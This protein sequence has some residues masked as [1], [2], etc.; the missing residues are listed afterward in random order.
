M[1]YTYHKIAYKAGRKYGSIVADR[2]REPI[3]VCASLND[4][5]QQAVAILSGNPTKEKK[6]LELGNSAADIDDI[7]ELYAGT[8]NTRNPRPCTGKSRGITNNRKVASSA[9][10]IIMDKE[11]TAEKWATMTDKQ[12]ARFCR[13]QVSNIRRK[14]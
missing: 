7:G 4:E 13:K 12:K 10:R 14:K 6:R 9:R 11:M 1:T 8:A 5:K 2:K 3:T